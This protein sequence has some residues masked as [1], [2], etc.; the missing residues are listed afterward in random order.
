[1][2]FAHAHP[3]RWGHEQAR[4]CDRWIG[5]SC[6]QPDAHSLLIMPRLLPFTRPA[7]PHCQA[8]PHSPMSN[9]GCRASQHS[10]TPA[11]MAFAIS[12]AARAAGMRLLSATS[13][14]WMG[15]LGPY[16]LRGLASPRGGATG[17]GHTMVTPMPL[18]IDVHGAA[19]AAAAHVGV[20][21]AAHVWRT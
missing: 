3:G 21:A 8:N 18:H 11:A 20:R 15:P 13:S 14:R 10:D 16:K 12:S 7:A 17:P 2:H 4:R 19:A 9:T 6:C 5:F 1:M